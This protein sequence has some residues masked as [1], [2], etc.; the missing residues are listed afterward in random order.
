MDFQQICEHYSEVR[1]FKQL[2][3][4]IMKVNFKK[5]IK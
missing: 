3:G 4:F 5:V 1:N 2:K